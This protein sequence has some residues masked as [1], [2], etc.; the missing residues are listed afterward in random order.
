[1]LEK[2]AESCKPSF[3]FVLRLRGGSNIFVRIIF[4]R[5][6]RGVVD[7]EAK[8]VRFRRAVLGSFALKNGMRRS[9]FVL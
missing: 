4:G 9:I 2:R 1:M 3:R 7:F 5:F 8:F 6:E